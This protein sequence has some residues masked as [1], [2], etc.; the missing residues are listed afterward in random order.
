MKRRYVWYA[1]AAFLIIAAVVIVQSFQ[2]TQAANGTATVATYSHGTLRVTIPYQAAH[3]GAGQLIVDVLDPEDGVVGRAER[4]VDVPEGKGRWQEDLKLT[5]EIAVDD[6]AWHRLR[7]RFTYNHEEAPA[8]EDTVSV[9]QMLRTPVLH[10]LGQQS[11]M[12]GGPAAV[13]VIVTDSNNEV[14]GGRS[15]LKIALL[16]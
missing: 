7:Y 10:I 14:I 4:P 9:S 13:R 3:A 5:K 16:P 2:P 8:I 12:T 1:T 11:Y 6:L 15:S